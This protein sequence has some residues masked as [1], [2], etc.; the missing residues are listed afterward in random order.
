MKQLAYTVIGIGGILAL[1]ILGK[2][3]LIPLTYGVVVWFLSRYFKNMVEQIP[4]FKQRLPSW[5]TSTLAFVMVMVALSLVAQLISSNVQSLLAS[6][7]QYQSNLNEVVAGLNAQFDFDL[8]TQL[9]EQIQNL[10]YQQMLSSVADGISSLLGN[11]SMILIY[12]VFLFSEEASFMMKF[13]KLFPNEA[14]Y[15]RASEILRKI[16]QSASDYIRLKT[17][18]SLLTGAISYVFLLIVGVEAPFFWSFLIFILNYIP[19]IG[20][21]IGTAFPA[22]FSLIQFGEITPFIIILGGVGATQLI[23]GNVIEPR[24]MGRS[25]NLS[26]LVTIL[27]LIVWGVIWGIPG[28]LLSVPITVI[29]VI[30]FSQFENTRKVAILLSENGEID[31]EA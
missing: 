24:I 27:A 3:T 20:S 19:T 30:I 26:P 29:M 15:A 2:D 5:V 28:M 22:V 6:S 8:Y 9:T 10:A 4:F 11:T 1:L 25:L 17:Y 18:V 31:G 13:Q 14:D 7:S 23:I 21:L 16:N 12:A